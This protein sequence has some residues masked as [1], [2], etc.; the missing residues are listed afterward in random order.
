MDDL[1]WDYP[2][3]RFIPHCE[4]SEDSSNCPIHLSHAEPIF[5]EG[6]LINLAKDI[7]F[8]FA[9][10]DRVAEIIVKSKVSAGRDRYKYY[11]DRGYPLHHHHLTEWED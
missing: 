5:E 7:P 6:L 2:K 3:G 9:R 11:R 1:M 10:F 8:F 4:M